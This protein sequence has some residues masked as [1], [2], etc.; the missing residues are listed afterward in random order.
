LVGKKAVLSDAFNLLQRN[1]KAV[2]QDVN[3]LAHAVAVGNLSERMD[4][5]KYQGNW[6]SIA[7]GLNQLIEAIAT[8]INETIDVTKALA[9]GDLNTKVQGNYEGAYNVLKQALNN[10]IE[11]LSSYI[12]DISETLGKMSNEDFDIL[13]TTEHIGDFA[14]IKTAMQQIVDKFNV[15]LSEINVSAEQVA[16]GAH[17]ISES[18]MSLATGSTEQAAAVDNWVSTLGDSP[19]QTRKNAKDAEEA[20]R[21]ASL[22]SEDATASNVKMEAM[23]NAMAQIN[24]ASN[25]I[26]KII[27]VIDDIAF[28][29]NLLALNAAVE[30]A[31]AGQQ[32]KGF[33]VVAEEVRSLAARSKDAAEETTALISGSVQKVGEG[34]RMANET[35]SSLKAI[36][37]QIADISGLVGGVAQASAK[38]EADIASINL[39][40]NQ[41]SE[42]T[43]NNTATS[44]GEAAASEELSSQ[45]EVFK[46]TVSRF[47]LKSSASG[48]TKS[49]PVSKVA[50]VNVSKTATQHDDASFDSSD[51]GKY[52]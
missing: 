27:K 31:R 38:Q 37:A 33:A 10:T 3:T 28:Q 13:V 24:E 22:A 50:H 5:E 11:T 2:T 46:N 6:L 45:A 23:L 16:A 30:A 40:I 43:Q 36:T 8:P 32:G 42:V 39:G 47:K 4:E 15:V 19:E 25:N 18:S 12:R 34:T 44:Q 48:K 7:E 17:Q 14:P 1:L 52:T 49:T 29:T 51:Y 41:I 26:S 21:L 20:N 35:A 9:Q